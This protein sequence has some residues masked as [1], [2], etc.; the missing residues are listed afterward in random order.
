MPTASLPPFEAASRSGAE[1]AIRM[2]DP[3]IS[4]LRVRTNEL[5]AKHRLPI[6]HPFPEDADAGG[7]IAYGPSSVF[8]YRQAATLVYRILEG[9]S[10]SSLPVEQPTKFE[11]SVNLKTAKTLGITVPQSILLRADRVIE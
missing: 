10:A 9:A 7:L 5:A 1:A 8:Q 11:L 2:V 6:I 3:T 4:M